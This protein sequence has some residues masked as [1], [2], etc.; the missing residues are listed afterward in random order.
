[1]KRRDFLKTTAKAAPVLVSFSSSLTSISCE[2]RPDSLEMRTLG[3]DRRK[4]ID[5]WIW[6]NCCHGCHA[7]T[8]FSAG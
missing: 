3:K 2:K 8:G 5:Y 1:M 4:I 6:W 7:G